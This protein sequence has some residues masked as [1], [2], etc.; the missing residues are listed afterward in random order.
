MSMEGMDRNAG[1]GT[2][3]RHWSSLGME[4]PLSLASPGQEHPVV[5][6]TMSV[7]LECPGHLR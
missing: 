7:G 5:I 4:Q 6:T 1:E 3:T 2:V